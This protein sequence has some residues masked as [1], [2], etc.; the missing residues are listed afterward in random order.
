MR[1]RKYPRHGVVKTRFGLAKLLP[2]NGT[3]ARHRKT[4]IDPDAPPFDLDEPEAITAPEPPPAAIAAAPPPR[5]LR[6]FFRIM[7][8]CATRTT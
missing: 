7:A 2:K 6:D 1:R 4:A 5:H 3:A 8:T